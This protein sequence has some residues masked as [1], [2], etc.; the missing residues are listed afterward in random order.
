MALAS[1]Y[2]HVLLVVAK[3]SFV[4]DHHSL[5]FFLAPNATRA[6]PPLVGKAGL[7][8][9]AILP[10]SVC[11]NAITVSNKGLG[12]RRAKSDLTASSVSLSKPGYVW[13]ALAISALL[14]SYHASIN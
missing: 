11:T 10:Y 4:T 12:A 9:Q 13:E 3:T 7:G 1:H 5:C 2:Y 8:Y 14:R 6:H